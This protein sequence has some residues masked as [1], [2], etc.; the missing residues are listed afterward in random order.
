MMFIPFLGWLSIPL[1]AVVG[2]YFTGNA[3]LA[4]IGFVIFA[5]CIIYAQRLCKCPRCNSRLFMIV[6]YLKRKTFLSNKA[7]YC[8]FCGV[9]FE[10]KLVNDEGEKAD[11]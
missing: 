4:L 7:D 9:S 2:I 1:L 5:S 6:Y 8:P 3:A 10:E 11:S